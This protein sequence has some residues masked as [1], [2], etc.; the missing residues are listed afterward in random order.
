MQN[1]LIIG[2]GFDL[3]HKL[4]TR[5]TDFLC[6]VKNW[7]EFY[8]KIVSTENADEDGVSCEQFAVRVDK[9]GRLIADTLNDFAMKSNCY[10]LDKLKELDTI[11]KSNIWIK[12]FVQIQYNKDSWIDF[13]SEIENV[14]KNIEL[15]YTEEIF[16]CEDKTVEES[17]NPLCFKIISFLMENTK[18]LPK[19]PFFYNKNTIELLVYGNSK[20]NLLDELKSDLDDLIIALDI[21]LEQFISKIK[22]DCYSKQI[23]ELGMINLLNFNYTYIFKTIY[24]GRNLNEIHQ[25][26]GSLQ[27]RDIVLGIS[28]ECFDELDY[29]YFQKYFQRIQ[30]RTGAFYRAWISDEHSAFDDEP[31]NLYILGHSL[32]ATDKGVLDEF[33][34]N[35]DGIKHIT[36]FYYNQTAYEELVIALIKLYGKK[37][38][39]EQTGNGRIEFVKL[40][41]AI[42]GEAK[43]EYN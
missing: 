1:I 10:D 41:Q 43:N 17:I 26:H 11:I 2:N 42:T 7:G 34:K 9:A 37:F 19:G 40:E 30:K 20:K 6:M 38:V 21:Y 13:E 25:I 36:I 27:E 33:F 32:G 39:I 28:D 4:P 14:L 29:V 3:Y 16:K 23:K 12:Y 31:V 5:Y 22:V 35:Y 8:S 18:S 15:F 24:G